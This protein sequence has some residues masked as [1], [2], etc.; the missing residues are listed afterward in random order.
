MSVYVLISGD[1][2]TWGGMDRANYEL[3]WFLAE[4]LSHPVHLVSHF[5]APPLAQHPLITW[6]RVAKPLNSDVLAEPRLNYHGQRVAASLRNDNPRVI[7]NGGNCAWGDVNWVHYVH[8]AY[9]PTIG[10]GTV[11]RWRAAW[12]H[13]RFLAAEKKA[14]AAA[15]IVI[16]NSD[17]T[18]S[19]LTGGLGLAEE[20]V[21][22]V[23]YGNNE[24][25]F[26]PP[27]T[28]QQRDARVALGW[29]PDRLTAVFVG[30]LGDQRKGFDV[31]FG[32]WQE[33][34][35]RADW[36]VDL[37]ALG[38]GSEL[39]FWRSR[40]A[41]QG[42]GE[43]IRLLGFTPEM[44][45]VMTAA[46][47]LISPT[48]YEAYGLGVHEALCRG[49]PAFVTRTAGIAE[50]YPRELDEL[51]LDAPPTVA[52]LAGRLQRWRAAREDYHDR[53]A[54]FSAQLRERSWAD[55]AREIVQQM[56]SSHRAG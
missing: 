42:L 50:R 34:I 9:T 2:T 4:G 1:F 43:R 52:D 30:G 45:R 25:E 53:V 36:D 38:V 10:Q 54:K 33:L 23:Y 7:V 28:G 51:L 15:R 20:R 3:A 56:E 48:R 13:R 24:G 32:A 31:A 37:V 40:V 19:D 41:A 46:D 12:S 55:M 18:R 5:V 8:A 11:R 22:T 35:C 29:D 49:I 17:R 21:R 44:S 39:E 47:L 14:L 26:S 16:A 6:H 27:S